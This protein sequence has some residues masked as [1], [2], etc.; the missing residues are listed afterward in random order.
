MT[1]AVGLDREETGAGGTGFFAC[2]HFNSDHRPDLYYAAGKGLINAVRVKAN[3]IGTLYETILAK[4]RKGEYLGRT[5]QV[6]PHVTDEIKA[7]IFKLG[8]ESKAD[9]LI[10]E[11]GGTVGDI[12]SQPFLEAIRQM[13]VE[14][15]RDRVVYVHLTLVPY[16]KAAAELKTK[17]TQ[18]SVGRLREIGIQPDILIC[19]SERPLPEGM[20]KKIA[21]FTNVTVDAAAL[22]V[23]A[24]NAVVLRGGSEAIRSNLAL[25]EQL[26]GAA[27]ETGFKQ[28]ALQADGRAGVA[29]GRFDDPMCAISGI[30]RYELGRPS[31]IYYGSAGGTNE[32]F[33]AAA[34][35][36]QNTMG[37]VCDP[38]QGMVEIPCHTRNA[39]AASNALHR[40]SPASMLALEKLVP[41]SGADPARF[42]V[43][44]DRARPP[45]IPPSPCRSPSRTSAAEPTARWSA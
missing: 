33:D 42:R 12:E 31:R 5:V 36:S 7:R 32:A 35:A 27:G 19:R 26:S 22:C 13:G 8:R 45:T 2:G 9:V 11:I 44:A 20:R 25:A 40:P 39:A 18:H 10:V 28:G 21:L 16:L 24:G 37:L 34:I 17:P 4:E 14:M 15:G 23:K 30:D 1:A 38:V 43:V 3:Q 41:G 29:Q 6:I